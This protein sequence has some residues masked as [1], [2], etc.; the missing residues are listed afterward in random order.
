M[1]LIDDALN[2]SE[3]L[4]QE[5]DPSGDAIRTLAWRSLRAWTRD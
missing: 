2:A 1:S 4:A 3:G 5:Y